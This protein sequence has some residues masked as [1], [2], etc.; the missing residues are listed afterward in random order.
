MEEYVTRWTQSISAFVPGVMGA[1]VLLLVAWL[2]STMI[3]AV[4]KRIGRASQLDTRL[5]SPG[6]TETAGQICYWLVFLIF[7]PGILS[8]L[9]LET[10][11]VPIQVMLN[12]L[13]GFLPNLMGAALILLVG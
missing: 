11:L 5:H 7:I 2:V 13:L 3:R 8:A 1:V 4:V 6:I 9:R 10:V 12:R